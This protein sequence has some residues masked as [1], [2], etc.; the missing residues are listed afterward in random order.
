LSEPPSGIR[1]VAVTPLPIAIQ[2]LQSALTEALQGRGH[3]RI[4]LDLG[5]VLDAGTP[6]TPRP[7]WRLHTAQDADPAVHRIRI[8]FEVG[9]PKPSTAEA[10][11]SESLPVPRPLPTPASG[12]APRSERV[13]DA[14]ALL[15][16]CRQVFGP[17]GFDNAARAEVFCEA[18]AGVPLEDLVRVLDHCRSGTRPL[19]EDPI[20][21]AHGRIHRV[22]QSAPI[23]GSEA[24]TRLHDCLSTVPFESLLATLHEHWRFGT[25][26]G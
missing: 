7:E 19:A 5:V 17:P 26:W 9:A 18:A 22:L 12:S 8:D 3:G 20:T 16:T 25:H 15:E 2:S 14:E 6:G 21:N 1:L 11:G 23:G 13:I 4:T 10:G 24:A